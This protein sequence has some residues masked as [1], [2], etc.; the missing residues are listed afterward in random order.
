MNIT[1]DLP[2]MAYTF[3]PHVAQTEERPDIVAWNDKAVYLVELTIPFE[4]GMVEAAERKQQKYSNLVACC[5]GNGFRTTLVT[6]E[7]GSRGFLHKRSL[8]NFYTL[9]K[10]TQNDKLAMEKEMIHRAILVSFRIWCRRNWL[11]SD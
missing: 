4:T 6:V 3:P 8:N 9:V 1:A 2:G 5:R 10:A 7:V 11:H